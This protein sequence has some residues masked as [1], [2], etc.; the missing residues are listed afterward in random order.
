MWAVAVTTEDDTLERENIWPY[1]TQKVSTWF[2]GLCNN[3]AHFYN[4]TIFFPATFRIL[5]EW[6]DVCAILRNAVAIRSYQPREV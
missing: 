1:L 5:P 4:G 3:C 2:T 6:R